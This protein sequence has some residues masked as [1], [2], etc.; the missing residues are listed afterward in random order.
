[1]YEG[2]YAALITPMTE[3]GIDESA[4]RKLVRWHIEQGTHGLVPVGTTGE[5]PTLTM[6]EHTR[7]ISIVVEESDSQIPIIAGAGSN[8]TRE[9]LVYNEHASRVGASATLHVAGYYNRPS[10][11]GLYQHF[12]TLDENSDIPIIVYN[13]PPRAIVDI[14]VE[15]MARMAELPHIVGVKD[16]TADL[17]RPLQERLVIDKPFSW[18]SG[19][20]GTAVAYNVSGGRGCISVTANVAPALCAEMQQACLSGDFVA[21]MAIQQ[22][23]MPLHLSLFAEPSPAGVKYAVSLLG[24]CDDRCRL[25]VVPLS[26]A[27]KAQIRQAMESLELLS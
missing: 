6:E 10:Q 17:S 23:L 15:T 8:N 19:E 11:E 1:M 18:L 2:S 27:T 4:L 21:A 7:V 22:R 26:D 14:S 16:A 13:I 3:D 5:S 12:K 9:A 25:P 20:D 24:L